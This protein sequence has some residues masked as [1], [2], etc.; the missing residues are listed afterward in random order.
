MIE[1][2]LKTSLG[3]IIV[4]SIDLTPVPVLIS[5]EEIPDVLQILD[6]SGLGFVFKYVLLLLSD[7]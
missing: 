4:T 6:I 7:F 3:Q 2:V 1:N 5:K